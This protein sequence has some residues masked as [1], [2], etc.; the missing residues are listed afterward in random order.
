VPRIAQLR[1]PQLSWSFLDTRESPLD[2]GKPGTGLKPRPAFDLQGRAV[3]LTAQVVAL[4]FQIDCL[5][6]GGLALIFI[7]S[8]PDAQSRGTGSGPSGSSTAAGHIEES[9][10]NSKR[11]PF[12]PS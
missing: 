8:S 11:Q 4:A 1:S 5:A 6:S 10:Q 9:E 12:G 7:W 3:H 2:L